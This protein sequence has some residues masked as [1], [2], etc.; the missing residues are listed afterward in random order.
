MLGSQESHIGL[1][2]EPAVEFYIGCYGVQVA[3][4]V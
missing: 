3:S 2:Y 1:L 4:G